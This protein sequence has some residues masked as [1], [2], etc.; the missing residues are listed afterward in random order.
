[1][2]A[3]PNPAQ[4][5]L[6]GNA[7]FTLQSLK[8]GT[9]FTFKVKM[10]EDNDSL[11]FVSCLVGP[12]NC[13]D[14][15]YFGFIRR[16]IFHHGGSKAKIGNDAPSV[17]AFRWFWEHSSTGKPTPQLEVSHEGR[18]GRCGRALTVPES[19]RSGF[20]SDC[21]EKMGMS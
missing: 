2:T 13:Q 12:D 6:A 10:A 20:G 8:T 16:G 1:M 9:R 14:Y 3:L 4:F 21:L 5:S 18:C 15:R 11:H 17:K 19:I 7:V